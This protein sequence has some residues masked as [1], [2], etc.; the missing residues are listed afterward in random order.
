M[1]CCL[2][3]EYEDE[4]QKSEKIIKVQVPEDLVPKTQEILNSCELGLGESKKMNS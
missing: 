4:F 2:I 1:N 3:T